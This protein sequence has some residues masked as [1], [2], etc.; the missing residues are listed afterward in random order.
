MSASTQQKTDS[1]ISTVTSVEDAA[2]PRASVT[3]DL[4]R[5][6]NARRILHTRWSP[7]DITVASVIAVASGL[8]FWMFDLVV[9]AP[10]AFLEG[11]IPGFSGI[12]SGFWYIAGP[13]AMLIV[14]KPGAAI[15]AETIGGLLEL[16]F[17]NQWGFSGSLV[18]GLVQG[19]FS[20]LV[21]AILLYRIWN[22]WSTAL[23]GL[24]TGLGGSLYSLFVLQSGLHPTGGY[25]ITNVMSNC[26]SGAIIS[27]ILMW[28]LFLAIAKTGALSHFASGRMIFDSETR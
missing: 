18:A 1:S 23:C 13:L 16:A 10:A 5:H 14:R 22:A 9:T 11:L 12:I 28:Y 25:V 24:V 15:Y 17:G 21:F 7:I 8:V 2:V 6:G 20:E 3:P 26:I 19:I 27:G 4:N